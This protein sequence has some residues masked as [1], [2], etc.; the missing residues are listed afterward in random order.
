MSLQKEAVCKTVVERRFEIWRPVKNL[1]PQQKAE[2]KQI[3]LFPDRSFLGRLLRRKIPKALID[4]DVKTFDL[5]DLVVDGGLNGLCGVAFDE[6]GSRPAVFN[7]GAIG[8]NIGTGPANDDTALGAEYMRVKGTY[9]KDA[10]TG[11]CSMDTTFNIDA[12]KTINEC[13]LLNA[14]SG[15]TL[16]CHD[17]IDPAKPVQDG[18]TINLYYTPKFQRPA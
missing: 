12:T 18:D 6:S 16:Y 1:T 5:E 8:T 3:Q 13:G 17:K 2:A 14:P 7:Y 10:A 4:V 9:T 15:G 11:E